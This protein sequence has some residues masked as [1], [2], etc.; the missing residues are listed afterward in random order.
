MTSVLFENL[1][2]Y[3]KGQGFWGMNLWGKA[4][5]PY[6]SRLRAAWLKL[7]AITRAGT[8]HLI[9]RNPSRCYEP[10]ISPPWLPTRYLGPAGVMSA[11]AL[12]MQCLG[13]AVA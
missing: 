2:T 4:S 8:E 10:R 3:Y 13:M 12:S 11:C 9:I 5:N 7:G 6:A 1:V